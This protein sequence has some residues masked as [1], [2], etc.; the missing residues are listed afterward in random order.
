M[1]DVGSW[2]YAPRSSTH[3]NLG[4]HF[5]QPVVQTSLYIVSSVSKGQ[6]DVLTSRYNRDQSSVCTVNHK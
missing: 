3:S 1:Y 2:L 4:I 5:M 6:G